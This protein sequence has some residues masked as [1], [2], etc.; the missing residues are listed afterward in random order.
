MTKRTITNAN[1][2]NNVDII[3]IDQIRALAHQLNLTALRDRLDEVIGRAEK[4]GLSYTDFIYVMFRLEADTRNSR[5]LTRNIKRSKL[6][7]VVEG[8]DDF[9]F[10]IRPKL[11]P[12][13]VKELLNCRPLDEGHNIICVGPP[14]RGKTRVLDAIGKAACLRGYTVLKTNTAEMLEDIHAS[15]VVG[16][17]KKTFER[18]EKPDLLICDEFGYEPFDNKATKYLFRLVSARYQK[19][20]IALA[21]NTGFQQWKNFFPSEAQAVAT[22][23]R[24]I[25]R[26]TIMR[27]S[28]KGCRK[29]EKVTGAE[30]QA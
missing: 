12:R 11:E 24:L 2:N 4:E 17:F 22:V 10:S 29:P 6:P 14:G 9:D 23:D 19:K 21:A 28:G 20:S 26:A 15:L 18:Y 5:R 27:F 13:V 3:D 16:T 1:R 25:D 8:L 7:A 30:A